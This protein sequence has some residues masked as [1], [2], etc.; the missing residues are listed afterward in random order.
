M[1]VRLSQQFTATCLS[2]S[3]YGRCR[4]GKTDVD[5][6][7]APQTLSIRFLALSYDFE[8]WGSSSTHPIV[9]ARCLELPEAHKI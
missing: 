8:Q 7:L 6:L 2:M 1:D 4:I 5:M 3:F 9:V